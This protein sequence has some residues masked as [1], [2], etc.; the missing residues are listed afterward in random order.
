MLDFWRW[1]TKRL[2]SRA[3]N[4]ACSTRGSFLF[5]F[6]PQQRYIMLN[7]ATAE[8]FIQNHFLDYKF[9]LFFRI[10]NLQIKNIK[11]IIYDAC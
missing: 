6:D 4:N 9:F 5:W 7:F 1:E 10:F 11:F 3:K 2:N 8:L